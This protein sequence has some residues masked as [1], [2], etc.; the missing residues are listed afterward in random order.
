MP[1]KSKKKSRKKPVTPRSK[2][3]A[4]LTMLFLRSRERAA[5]IKRDENRCQV[6]QIKGSKAK[7]R[8]VSTEVHHINGARKDRIIDMIYEHLLCSPDLLQVVCR[9]CHQKISELENNP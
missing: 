8:E 5:A 6:C 1:I 7:G 3:R 9:E 2:V 4:A